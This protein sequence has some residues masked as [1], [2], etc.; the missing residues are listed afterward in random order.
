LQN[1]FLLRHCEAFF[2]FVIAKLPL[3]PPLGAFF[4]SPSLQ[5][6]FLLVIAR[7]FSSSQLRSFFLHP[8]C[9]T[10]LFS[11]LRGFFFFVIARHFSSWSLQDL[12]LLCH[13][14]IFLFFV[15]ARLS[16]PSSLRGTKCRSNLWF[17]SRHFIPKSLHRPQE[18]PEPVPK[19]HIGPTGSFSMSLSINRT[20]QGA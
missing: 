6:V 16:S 11:S 14:K 1:L 3:S 8:H 18:N 20:H 5:G 19:S 4:P 10:S 15:I 12:S 17:S 7:P 13:C 2:S 9:E